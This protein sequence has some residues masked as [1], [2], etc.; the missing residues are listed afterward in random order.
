MMQ[1]RSLFI[2]RLVSSTITGF[3][4]DSFLTK[5]VGEL[6]WGYDSKLVDFLKNYMPSQMPIKG[7]FGLFSEV[8]A[9]LG[10]A[11]GEFNS[12]SIPHDLCCPTK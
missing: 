9:S 1:H 3:G 11:C 8:T 12:R 2:R 5:T 4:E 7:K 6:M 10:A